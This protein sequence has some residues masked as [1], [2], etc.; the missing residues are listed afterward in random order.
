M[1]YNIMFSTVLYI[2]VWALVKCALF[3]RIPELQWLSRTH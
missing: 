3:P 2:I 1:Q